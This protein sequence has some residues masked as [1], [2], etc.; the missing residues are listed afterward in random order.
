MTE[1]ALKKSVQI[2][3]TNMEVIVQEKEEIFQAKKQALAIIQVSLVKG[4]VSKVF[5]WWPPP[6]DP[7]DQAD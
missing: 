7:T 2:L 1:R 3:D 6:K 5:V 4:L